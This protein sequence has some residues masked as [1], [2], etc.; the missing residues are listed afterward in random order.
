VSAGPGKTPKSALVRIKLLGVERHHV[1]MILS[2]NIDRWLILTTG[3]AL[4][5]VSAWYS[6]T[7]LTAIFAGA[8]W[9]IIILGGT[10]E[11][12][13]IILASWLYRNWK[14][15]PFLMKTYFTSALI[16]L[17]IITSM[18]IFGFLSKAHLDQ[19]APSGDIVAKIERI[20]DNIARERMRVTR[21][22]QQL[23]QLDKA[24][25]SI[26]DRNNRAQ[27]ALQIRQQQKKERDTLAAE[28]KDAQK[29]IDTMLDEKAPLMK[30]TRAIKLE[31]GPIRYVAELIYGESN[32]RD[33]ESAIRIMILLLVFVIDPLAVLL[34]IAA[35]KQVRKEVENI[36]AVSTN[37]DLWE[38][39]IIEKKS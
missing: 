37:G 23:T 17:M 14:Y 2:S 6:V 3:V 31:V 19:V 28:I 39:M 16:I 1:S 26:I 36:E 35:S 22:E 9:A 33:L 5:V 20:D 10:L 8:Y 13:K 18:G 7:G 30:T 34:I 11:F 4:S 25:D 32:E 24:I 15:I 29:N 38:P 21:A 27:T 12:G